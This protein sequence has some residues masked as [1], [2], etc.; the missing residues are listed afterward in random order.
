MGDCLGEIVQSRFSLKKLNRIISIAATIVVVAVIVFTE[1]PSAVSDSKKPRD[2]FGAETVEPVPKK[3]T[4]EDNQ[5]ARKDVS[6][7]DISEKAWP[8]PADEPRPEELIPWRHPSG[9]NDK[10]EEGTAAFDQ[11][12]LLEKTTVLNV[13][14]VEIATLV[15]TFSK[16]TGRNYIVDSSVKGK[17]TIHLPTPVTV[18][19]AL[20]ILESVLLL[21]GFT[22]V[23]V[24]KNTWK[25]ILA[26]DARQTTIPL[27]DRMTVSPSDAVVT[28]MLKLKNIPA[29][30]MQQLLSQFISKDGFI[31]S[32]PGTNSLVVVDSAANLRRLRELVNDLDVPAIDQEISV[33]PVYYAEATD[34][35]EKINKILGQE[36]EKDKALSP[37]R[38]A[39][40]PPGF[41]R[42]PNTGGLQGN[43][44]SDTS[45]ERRALP[46]KIIPDERTN[47]LIVVADQPLTLKVRA[48]VEQLDSKFDRSAGR[49]WVYRLQH[50]D[51]ESV[52][53]VIG[54][55]IS[56]TGGSPSSS[57]SKTSLSSGSSFTRSR[58]GGSSP[59][60][61]SG[62]GDTGTSRFGN[63]GQQQQQS[64]P[65]QQSSVGV[66]TGG[67][68][69]KDGKVTL[70]GEVSVAPDA[71]TNSLIINA[72]RSDY[73]RLKEVIEALDVK[74]RQVLVEAT[75][76]EVTLTDNE[77]LG[78]ELQGTAG[79]DKGGII[80]QTNFGGITS[81]LTNPAALT[82]LTIAA[83]STGTLTLPGGLVIPSQAVLVSA[84][85]RHSNVNV[86]STPTILTTDNEE[87]KIIVG[88]NVPFV[89]STSTNNTNLNNT[90]NQVER[91]DVG[92]SVRIT[93]QIS[94]G[95]FV[96]LKIF[97]EI[98]DVVEATRGD[99]NGP[100]TNIRTTETAV[101]IKNNQM[102]VTG[103]LLQDRTEASTR[104]VPFFQ[105]IPFIGQ[106][107][108]RSGDTSRKTNL[109][110][111][112]T[113][114]IV[115]D[116]YDARHETKYYSAKVQEHIAEGGYEPDR[117]ETLEDDHMDNVV[118]VVPPDNQ[119]LPTTIT[120][121]NPATQDERERL[122][123]E[124]TKNRF[125][126]LMQENSAAETERLPQGSS[127]DVSDRPQHGAGNSQGE[128]TLELRVTPILPSSGGGDSSARKED[129][130]NDR[131]N[132][133]AAL[134]IP[135]SRAKQAEGR[136]FVV[137][138]ELVAHSAADA[139]GIVVFGNPSGETSRFFQVGEQ[140]H[141]TEEAP[142]EATSRRFVCIGVYGSR[143][144]AQIV[145]PALGGS[146]A[147][148]ELSL[149]DTLV[150][151]SGPW[152]KG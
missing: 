148:H 145:H 11:Q 105:D 32:F 84:L 68:S 129:A 110:L 14:D 87:A 26:K 53:E 98:S 75:V 102:I 49:F 151:G 144:E 31:K 101:E 121:P 140:Y 35:A 88:E 3:P 134:N 131:R 120:G 21:K 82:D 60:L 138:K 117:H 113:P 22:S 51:A 124:R 57:K 93:P 103:G 59:G 125:R 39:I 115:V 143:E 46:L 142:K 111:F 97:I 77:D 79:Y 8:G 91:Q 15:K 122:A 80:A 152:K 72:S 20:R 106:L 7:V 76:L 6:P 99:P 86:L 55:L 135:S 74:R 58:N 66:V 16:L 48:L 100:T 71:A 45:G 36:D 92:I 139:F 54:N 128:D 112:V 64:R 38:N 30:D 108:K 41:L 5:F 81:L 65:T 123:L 1:L 104:G 137:L 126:S 44:L 28:E 2:D 27:M 18:A 133:K 95:D 47:S 136:T 119:H 130:R 17:V 29:D 132:N 50:A 141:L 73:Q 61:S 9:N 109:L 149:A 118:E 4:G 116:Q 70:E 94:S 89:T 42:P 12:K 78:V 37:N 114:K 67:G 56:G 146:G 62:F 107:M 43:Q 85:S 127:G 147:W 63:Q 83:A 13:T 150:L 69:G 52:A 19:E 24:E 90:F 23:P 40:Q 96:N 34:L 25:I 33:I 10:S